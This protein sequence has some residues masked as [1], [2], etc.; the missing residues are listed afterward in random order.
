MT[1]AGLHINAPGSRLRAKLRWRYRKRSWPHISD[2][3]TADIDVTISTDVVISI[4]A[5][6]S[7]PDFGLN[8]AVAKFHTNIDRLGINLH[9]GASWLYQ[10]RY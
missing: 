5:N 4:T 3:G 2:H 9:G 8:V 7:D 6:P 1:N 10:V